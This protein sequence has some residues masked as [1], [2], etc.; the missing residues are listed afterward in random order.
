MFE[1]DDR[2]NRLGGS[3]SGRGLEESFASRRSPSTADKMRRRKEEDERRGKDSLE[4][5]RG[6]DAYR[7]I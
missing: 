7:T 2:W 5:N 4:R 1:A 3:R 6:G